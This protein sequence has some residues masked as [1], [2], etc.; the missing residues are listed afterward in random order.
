MNTILLYTEHCFP[1]ILANFSIS[2]KQSKMRSPTKYLK[3]TNMCPI[4]WRQV[5]PTPTVLDSIQMDSAHQIFLTLT[6]NLS[7]HFSPETS[8][9]GC[10]KTFVSI[11]WSLCISPYYKQSVILLL[12]SEI[13]LTLVVVSIIC[14]IFC[15]MNCYSIFTAVWLSSFNY[16]SQ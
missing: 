12:M 1:F 7:R 13:S 10:F 3:E 11:I 6:Y 8:L 4:G 5:H 15:I 9:Y 2:C 14:V 16:P